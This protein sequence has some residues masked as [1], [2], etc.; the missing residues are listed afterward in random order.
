MENFFTK[1][2]YFNNKYL[3]DFNNLIKILQN[4]YFV[5]SN[6]KYFLQNWLKTIKIEKLYAIKYILIK[7]F[8]N[9]NNIGNNSS[10]FTFRKNLTSKTLYF[11]QNRLKI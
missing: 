2:F 11:L 5:K 8:K 1:G 6:P 7:I 9:F 10:K 4:S 3:K